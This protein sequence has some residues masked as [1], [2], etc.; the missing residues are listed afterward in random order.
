MKRLITK[1]SVAISSS[2]VFALML[3]GVAHAQESALP[4]WY[5]WAT[6]PGTSAIM[7]ISVVINYILSFAVSLGGILINFGLGLDQ[8]VFQSPTVLTGFSVALSIANLGFVLGIIVIAIATILRSQSYGIKQVLWKL[9]VMAILVNFG[10]VITGPIVGLADNFTGYFLQAM[11][12]RSQFATSLTTAFAPSAFTTAPV[13]TS[14]PTGFTATN[15]ACNTLITFPGLSTICQI[16]VGKVTGT[17]T[18]GAGDFMRAITSGIFS[19]VFIGIAA[20]TLILVGILLL[21]RYVY[22]NILLILLPLAWLT[23][24]FPKF[25][26]FS[27]WWGLF[28]KWSLFPAIVLFF[29]YIAVQSVALVNGQVTVPA[30]TIAAGDLTQ[31]S[32]PYISAAIQSGQVGWFQTALDELVLVGL[33]LG[34]IFAANSLSLQGADTIMHGAKW[35]GGQV[36]G[37]VG[38]QT[39]KRS[40]AAFRAVGGT[41]AVKNMRQ[42]T[43]KISQA[44]KGIPVVGKPASW[45]T[46]RVGSIA[47]RAAEPHL[48]NAAMVE[49]AKKHVPKSPVEIKENLRGNMNPETTFAHISTLR[50]MGE[51][52]PETMVR[53]QKIGDFLDAHKTDVE[54][55]GWGKDAKD[56]DKAIGSNEEVRAAEREVS[57]AKPGEDLAKAVQKLNSATEKF[58]KDWKKEDFAKVNVNE[59]FGKDTPTAQ[60]LA[61]AIT[62]NAPQFIPTILPKMKAEN[63]RAFNE[64]FTRSLAKEMAD[65]VKAGNQELI[66]R[67]AKVKDTYDRS[68]LRNATGFSA[69]GGEGGSGGGGGGAH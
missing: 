7:L 22:L 46:T 27:K 59:V 50:G 51:L 6:S 32:N 2:G 28:L 38:K 49:E 9:V 10:L 11:G 36:Q 53:D 44:L 41:D 62:Y 13:V 20:F 18:T 68:Y 33:C 4:S 54:N 25:N 31:S 23:W 56:S 43:G 16:A 30:A 37:Y 42:G 45:V 60:A 52:S 64:M 47:G 14:A 15:A 1:F 69:G 12:G 35:V 40:R 29:L 66:D 55:Y 48:T 8:N 61:R 17:D 63:L 67:L 39:K 57:I 24:I 5:N 26:Y 34:G 3:T 65:A 21:V 58:I 19:A